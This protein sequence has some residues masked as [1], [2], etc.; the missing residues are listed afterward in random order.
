VPVYV[1]AL[2]EQTA[3]SLESLQRTLERGEESRTSA[4]NSISS[5]TERL[6]TLTDQMRTEQSLMIRLAETQM[7]MKPLLARLAD[8]AIHNGAS[9]DEAVANNIRSIDYQM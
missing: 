4:N 5:L 2:L 3:D 7:E 6:V 9:M 8:G 1:Q